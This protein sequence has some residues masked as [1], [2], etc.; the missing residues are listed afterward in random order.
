M[1]QDDM[2]LKP[3]VDM[4][5][6][7]TLR[8]SSSNCGYSISGLLNSLS[9]VTGDPLVSTTVGL[10]STGP[11]AASSALMAPFGS[12]P[13]LTY[14]DSLLGSSSSSLGAPSASGSSAGL[15][16]VPTETTGPIRPVKRKQRRYRTTFSNFQ[17]EELE[18]AF[19]KTHYP[20]VFFREELAM[21]IDLTEARVQVWFQNRR[22][23]WRKQE[24]L[25]AKQ[26]QQLNQSQLVHGSSLVQGIIS[27]PV[28][29]SPSLSVE[30]PLLSPS[31]S[32]SGMSSNNV[33][34]SIGGSPLGPFSP[35]VGPS[36]P[37][38]SPSAGGIFFG[39][40]WGGF[41]P[42]HLSQHK[43]TESTEPDADL[44]RLKPSN[45]EQSPSTLLT[46]E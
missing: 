34:F 4:T 16:S 8:T 42:Y 29:S 25:A 32:L 44:L 33:P 11:I 39:V 26:H 21:R 28:T 27:I 17:L 41:S 15:S 7:Q 18:R 10:L 46:P 37:T 31:Q 9:G 12:T 35:G 14:T 19:H 38:S 6:L 22:A 40:E 13:K 43:S 23:K 45:K 1:S 20:D 2:E 3:L 24:K 36:L 30:S 5:E